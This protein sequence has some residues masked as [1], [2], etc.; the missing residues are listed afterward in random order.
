MSLN[1][2]SLSPFVTASLY[3]S[4]LIANDSNEPIVKAPSTE[5]KPKKDAVKDTMKESVQEEKDQTPADPIAIGWKHLGSNN[6]NILIVVNHTDVTHL[7]DEELGFLT[8]ILSACKLDLGDVSIINMN[9][10]ADHNYKDLIS[11]FSSKIVLLFGYDPVSFGLP[12]DFPHYQVQALNN[13]TFLFSPALSERNADP[14][15]KS[16]LWVCLKR[17][18]GI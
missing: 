11:H 5:S 13:T 10:Y 6:K 4:S 17:I 15:F 16:K 7:P 1:D 12:V 14:L 18:F 3:R 2:I 8:A 9:N